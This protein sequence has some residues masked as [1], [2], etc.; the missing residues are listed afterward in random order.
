MQFVFD[1]SDPQKIINEP[2]FDGWTCLHIAAAKGL[3][4]IVHFGVEKGANVNAKSMNF[5]ISIPTSIPLSAL[6]FS[7]PLYIDIY[8][9]PNLLY[10]L[11]YR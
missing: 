6:L 3:D 8:F 2:N 10:L 5:L 11:L 7:L 1:R 9:T 4:D